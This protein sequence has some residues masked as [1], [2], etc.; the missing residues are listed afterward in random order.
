MATPSGGTTIPTAVRNLDAS[1]A[2][3]H[4]FHG[5]QPAQG[6]AELTAGGKWRWDAKE[7]THG[8]PDNPPRLS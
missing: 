8:A 6:R 5:Q 1:E 2:A 4:R 3:A 7:A